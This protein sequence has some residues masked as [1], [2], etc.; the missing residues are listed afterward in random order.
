[1]DNT[2]Q[3]VTQWRDYPLPLAFGGREYRSQRH[4][5]ALWSLYP[6]IWQ[7]AKTLPDSCCLFIWLVRLR[8][9]FIRFRGWRQAT[10]ATGSR[11]SFQRHQLLYK[12]RTDVTDQL[13]LAVPVYPLRSLQYG[14][15]KIL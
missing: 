15:I 11:L 8:L 10:H 12:I 9:L 4:R 13:L 7:V 5:P 3:L 1:M 2:T 6:T 14:L